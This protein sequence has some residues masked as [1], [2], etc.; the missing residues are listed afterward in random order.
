MP[1]AWG[2]PFSLKND[3]I[4]DADISELETD[5]AKGRL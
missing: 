1:I 4:N 2:N 5:F 3:H